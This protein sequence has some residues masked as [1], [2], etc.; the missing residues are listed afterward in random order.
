MYDLSRFISAQKLNYEDALR[1][2]KSGHKSTH[3]IWYIFPQLKVLGFSPTARYYGIENLDETKE[4]LSNEILREHLLE[5]SQALLS[6]KSNDIEDIMGNEI[7]KIKL[8]SSMTLFYLA[9]PDCKILIEV[10]D[11]YFDG[12]SDDKTVKF[13]KKIRSKNKN[14]LAEHKCLDFIHRFRRKATLLNFSQ[15][16]FMS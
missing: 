6:I 1:E 15:H 2:I 3:W 7:D 12:K 10:I 8:L 4:Y 11:K 14:N 5:I 13:C 9:E 16:S